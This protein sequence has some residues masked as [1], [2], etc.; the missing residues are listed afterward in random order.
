MAKDPLNFSGEDV[1]RLLKA[2]E[3]RLADREERKGFYLVLG[4]LG[5]LV[6]LLYIV[7]SWVLELF[8]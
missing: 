8:H 4:G 2:E 5:C 7:G 3:Q 1:Q 6:A